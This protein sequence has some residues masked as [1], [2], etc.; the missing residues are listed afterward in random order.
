VDEVL[1][2]GR[3][4][5]LFGVAWCVAGTAALFYAFGSTG[6]GF[7]WYGAFLGSLIHWYRALIMYRA[8]LRLG[9]R[10][11]RGSDFVAVGVAIALVVG[12]VR[13]L[14][15]EYD[16]MSSPKLGTCWSAPGEDGFSQAIACWSDKA[17]FKTVAVVSSPEGCWTEYYM[18]ESAPKRTL[19]NAPI[20]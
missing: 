20:D 6:S 15:P 3:R 13:L 8:S 1:N 14:V 10:V 12:A 4:Q 19:C 11:L 7:I 17:A 18:E 2:A 9:W 5:V 16:K